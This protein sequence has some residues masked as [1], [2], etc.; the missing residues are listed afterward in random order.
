M[1]STSS[2]DGVCSMGVNNCHYII[3]YISICNSSTT[4]ICDLVHI[5]FHVHFSC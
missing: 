1:A 5:V 4:G 3:Q 2:L